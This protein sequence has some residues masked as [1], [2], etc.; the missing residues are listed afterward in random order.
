MA[1]GVCQLVPD[2]PDRRL[3]R[4]Q[5]SQSPRRLSRSTRGRS[6]SP[7]GA[8]CVLLSA[9]FG[10]VE[11]L[12]TESD[13]RGGV[14]LTVRPALADGATR[15]HRHLVADGPRWHQT[16]AAHAHQLRRRQRCCILAGESAIITAR[17]TVADGAVRHATACERRATGRLGLGLLPAP[18]CSL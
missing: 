16:A 5:P 13:P 8:G 18:S 15:D 4:R 17:A 7:A 12:E 3:G 10:G 6:S 2:V 14:C 9:F 1:R 11:R